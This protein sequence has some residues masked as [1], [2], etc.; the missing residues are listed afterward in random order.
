MECQSF[1][2]QPEIHTQTKQSEQ[3]LYH[4]K[5]SLNSILQVI[6]TTHFCTGAVR[7]QGSNVGL[8]FVL[9]KQ[10][11][12]TQFQECQEK[13]VSEIFT[14]EQIC[15]ACFWHGDDGLSY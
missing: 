6:F 13:Q 11:H 8:E 15:F 3:V 12:N 7:C 4:G 14:F 10:I 1:S 2:F 9:V 5:P